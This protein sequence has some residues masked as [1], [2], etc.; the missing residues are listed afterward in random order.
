MLD[1]QKLDQNETGS[2]HHSD[3]STGLECTGLV[4]PNVGYVGRRTAV[5]ATATRSVNVTERGTSLT[6]TVS[7]VNGCRSAQRK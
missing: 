4:S 5:P 2:G 6:V 1:H 7:S 3:G